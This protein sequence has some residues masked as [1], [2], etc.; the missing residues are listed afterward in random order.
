MRLTARFFVR[1]GIFTSV[2]AEHRKRGWV[3]PAPVALDDCPPNRASGNEGGIAEV[4]G[5]AGLSA[6]GFVAQAAELKVLS[7]GAMRSAMTEIIASYEKASGNKIDATYATAGSLGRCW[8]RAMSPMSSSCRRRTFAEA[9]NEGWVVPGT[10][11]DLASVGIGM[12]V[13]AGAPV[14]GHFDGGEIPGGAP[15]RAFDRAHGPGARHQRQAPRRGLRE[16]RHRRAIAG[17][18]RSCNRKATW[19]IASRAARPRSACTR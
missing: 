12:A 17:P 14:P 19:P 1:G 16:R 10:R 8:R 6:L 11:V 15:R 5:P 3:A 2:V 18:S 13:K 7:A 9:E 4:A